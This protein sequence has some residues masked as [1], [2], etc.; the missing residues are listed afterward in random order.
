MSLVAI[1][2][3]YISITPPHLSSLVSDEIS[4]IDS[5]NN[6]LQVIS[7]N[8]IHYHTARSLQQKMSPILCDWDLNYAENKKVIIELWHFFYSIEKKHIDFC[9][10]RNCPPQCDCHSISIDNRLLFDH[11]WYDFKTLVKTINDMVDNNI[12]L[13]VKPRVV[14]TMDDR[15]YFVLTDIYLNMADNKYEALFTDI[16]YRLIMERETGFTN[17][18]KTFAKILE[19]LE[20][21]CVKDFKFVGSG[22]TRDA[23]EECVVVDFY[24]WWSNFSVFKRRL[25]HIV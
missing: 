4:L 1:T 3:K 12:I 25:E 8:S 16:F 14:G 18:P 24:E 11:W 17:N 2:Q 23:Y 15:I 5:I 6:A 10:K 7:V 9:D 22:A 19:L 13:C 20:M 21:I